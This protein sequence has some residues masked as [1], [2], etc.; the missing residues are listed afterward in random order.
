MSTRQKIIP[1]GRNHKL[2]INEMQ[3][4]FQRDL[5]I[6]PS[7]I[8]V[9]SGSSIYM[10]EFNYTYYG[11]RVVFDTQGSREPEKQLLVVTQPG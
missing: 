8:E 5:A 2:V 6:Y 4:F 3:L 9:T 1:P 11:L 10:H 7:N